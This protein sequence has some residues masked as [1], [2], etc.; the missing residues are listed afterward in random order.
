MKTALP[1][2]LTALLLLSACTA[3]EPPPAPVEPQGRAETRSIRNTQAVGYDG[4]AIADKVDGALNANDQRVQE[5]R[6]DADAG[7][8]PAE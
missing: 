5:I 8:P 4:K 1:P 7:A 6:Q 2:L 3:E